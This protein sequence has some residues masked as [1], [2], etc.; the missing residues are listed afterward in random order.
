MILRMVI[1]GKTGDNIAIEPVD[2]L[3]LMGEMID[4]S[5]E[6]WTVEYLQG[7]VETGTV[8]KGYINIACSFVWKN[9][10]LIS[11][12]KEEFVTAC[13]KVRPLLHDV[14]N[15][16]KGQQWLDKATRDLALALVMNPFKA[17]TGG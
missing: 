7:L 16:P 12:S 14:I 6:G 4:L 3:T 11:V 5:T 13:K 9:P 10:G 17:L 2:R 8:P 15:T 1:P